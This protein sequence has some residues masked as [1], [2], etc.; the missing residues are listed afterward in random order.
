MEK[1]FQPCLC[2]LIVLTHLFMRI[3]TVLEPIMTGTLQTSWMIPEKMITTMASVFLTLHM[4]RLCPIL[5]CVLHQKERAFSISATQRWS[6]KESKLE[7][8]ETIMPDIWRNAASTT[9][10]LEMRVFIAT[11]GVFLTV[12]VKENARHALGGALDV[13]RHVIGKPDKSGYFFNMHL[14]KYVEIF[15]I[16]YTNDFPTSLVRRCHSPSP[17]WV[18]III[19]DNCHR[20]HWSLFKKAQGEYQLWCSF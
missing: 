5:K 2:V 14:P 12:N 7:M 17:A 6:T 13:T 9:V 16:S 18:G 15:I 3:V 10:R 20:R 8:N 1:Y 19:V 4:P 11:P